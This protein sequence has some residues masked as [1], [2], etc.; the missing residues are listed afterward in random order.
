MVSLLSFVLKFFPAGDRSHLGSS[1][2]LLTQIDGTSHVCAAIM[3]RGTVWRNDDCSTVEVCSCARKLSADTVQCSPVE[4]TSSLVLLIVARQYVSEIL[5]YVDA[6]V[7]SIN[8]NSTCK[9]YVAVYYS[10]L[11]KTCILS[12]QPV[13]RIAK[14]PPTR[15]DQPRRPGPLMMRSLVDDEVSNFKCTR[16]E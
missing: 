14:Q 3:T 10:H 12:L 6:I 7:V 5:L 16:K 13:L 11:L 2:C 1:F 15:S 9:N 4:L 8:S